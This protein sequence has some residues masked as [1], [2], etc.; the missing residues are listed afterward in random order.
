MFAILLKKSNIMSLYTLSL[1]HN[2]CQLR[3]NE[4]TLYYTFAHLKRLLFII[5]LI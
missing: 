3:N 2:K 4:G 1:K 5:K